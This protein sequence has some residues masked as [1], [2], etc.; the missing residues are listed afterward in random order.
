METDL[1][2]IFLEICKQ[3]NQPESIITEPLNI[4][5]KNFFFKLK[6]LKRLKADDWDKLNLPSNLYY[7]IQDKLSYYESNNFNPFSNVE[8]KISKEDEIKPISQ[9]EE[10]KS[11]IFKVDNINEVKIT[12]P[13][14]I[15]QIQFEAK[16]TTEIV[17][18]LKTLHGIIERIVQNPLDEAVQKINTTSKAYLSKIAPYKS[19]EE[20][21][22]FVGFE[23]KKTEQGYYF[24]FE[25]QLD[26]LKIIYLDFGNIL[27]EK[28]KI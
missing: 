11:S 22:I 13:K 20:M 24:C 28:S 27:K 10:K 14:L 8:N 4:L 2:L 17:S 19:A 15:E 16:V 6:D 5:Q 21:L 3:Y 1:K 18:T 26:L 25:G 12:L 23:K 7:V 9:N